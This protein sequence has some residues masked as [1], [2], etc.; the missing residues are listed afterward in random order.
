ML[1]GCM[2]PLSQEKT[3]L[4]QLASFKAAWGP[5]VK[6]MDCIHPFITCWQPVL[7]HW[8]MLVKL[9]KRVLRVA[10]VCV[11]PEC[12]TARFSMTL[13]LVERLV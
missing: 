4:M 9:R 8:H 2:T 11:Q 12:N 13:Y 5:L 1:A 6:L 10:N 3:S 7:T